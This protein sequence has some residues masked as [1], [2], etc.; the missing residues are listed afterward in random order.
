RLGFTMVRSIAKS[1]LHFVHRP[2]LPLSLVHVDDLCRA[3]LLVAR[4]G[5]RLNPTNPKGEGVYYVA[6]PEVSS[7]EGVGR[8]IGEALDRPVRVI[9]VRRWALTTA[10]AVGELSGR[11]RGK[12]GIVNFDK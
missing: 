6:D 5:E 9:K 8:M 11:W 2:G 3:I 1:G 10:A 7:H 4:H 12:P